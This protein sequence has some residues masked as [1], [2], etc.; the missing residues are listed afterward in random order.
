MHIQKRRH[1]C[2][3]SLVRT[4]PEK[5]F[6]IVGF[7]VASVSNTPPV[8]AT[9][10]VLALYKCEIV[11]AGDFIIHTEI[12]D[13]RHA[14]TFRDIIASFNYIQQVPLHPTHRGG[15]TLALVVTKVEQ[16][17]LNM[18]IDPPDVISDHSIISC[19]LYH[20][21]TNIQFCWSVNAGAGANSTKMNSDLHSS[22]LSCATSTVVQTL[23]KSTLYVPLRST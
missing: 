18:A 4:V 6:G 10:E 8:F 13:D 20:S 1:S 23:W 15:G 3:Q 17:V 11:S 7:L 22:T 16:E 21:I 2:I 9:H 14:M 19:H 5:K 12:T